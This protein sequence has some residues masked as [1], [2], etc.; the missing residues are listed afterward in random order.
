[1]T[2]VQLFSNSSSFS[3]G[4]SLYN[5]PDLQSLAQGYTYVVYDVGPGNIYEMDL[6]ELGDFTGF[7]CS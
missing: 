5:D 7:S 6:G 4:I 1:M 2:Q 3:P